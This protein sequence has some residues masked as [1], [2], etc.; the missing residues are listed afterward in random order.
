MQDFS[1]MLKAG[2]QAVAVPVADEQI[3]LLFAYFTEL[4]KWSEKINL[5]ARGTGD[6]EIIE[7]HFLDSLSLLRILPD[8]SHLLDVGSGAGFPGLVCR[9]A[10][11]NLRV[12]LVEPRLKRVSFL[13]HLVRLLALNDVQILAGRIENQQLLPSNT[14]FTHAVSRA[15]GGIGSF[16]QMLDRFD[17]KKMQ[18]ICMKGPKWRQELENARKKYGITITD[19]KVENIEL[20]LTRSQRAMVHFELDKICEYEQ[21]ARK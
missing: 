10:R 6:L 7:K 14:F 20:P 12:T 13:K 15:V 21:N 8:G 2:L 18:V 5:I 1:A 19:Y 9:A 11:P 4:K 17:N 3:E 16:C